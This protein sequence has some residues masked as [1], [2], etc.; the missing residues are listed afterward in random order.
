MN[1]RTLIV[2][3]ILF[4]LI[5]G[6]YVLHFFKAPQAPLPLVSSESPSLMPSGSVAYIEIDS[7]VQAYDYYYD[8]KAAFER[9]QKNMEEQLQA[10]A[11]I[12]ENKQMDFMKKTEKGLLTRS[13]Q[14]EAEQLLRSEQESLYKLRDDMTQQLAEEEHILLKKI[15]NEIQEY[16]KKINRQYNF[17]IILS[18]N[19]TGNIIYGADSLNITKPVI[20][21]LNEEYKK[22]KKEKTAK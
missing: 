9:K 7:L 10:K 2:N 14:K 4:L 8:L 19:A 17:Q 6:L 5:A 15:Y 1:K 20:N 11:K 18:S 13:E 21:G 12:F 3:L 16:V 22:K